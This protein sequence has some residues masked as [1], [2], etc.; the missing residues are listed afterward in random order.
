MKLRTLTRLALIASLGFA[1]GLQAADAYVEDDD[2]PG[3]TQKEAPAS[4]DRVASPSV[5]TSIKGW[6]DRF[7]K[8]ENNCSTC[9]E[10]RI[11]DAELHVLHQKQGDKHRRFC[12]VCAKTPSRRLQAY[13]KFSV[14]KRPD[15]EQV[16]EVSRLF[17]EIKKLEENLHSATG[18]ARKKISM[19]LKK[20]KRAL[21]TARKAAATNE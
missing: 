9:H 16:N 18:D 21:A 19:E 6:V 15:K 8:R 2:I 10:H 5:T 17:Q 3:A 1:Q 7:L 20:L 11:N 14:E 12:P 13:D 4:P